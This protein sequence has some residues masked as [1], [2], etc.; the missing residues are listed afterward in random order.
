MTWPHDSAHVF[1]QAPWFIYM[2]LISTSPAFMMTA[3]L[4][5]FFNITPKVLRSPASLLVYSSLSPF[6]FFFY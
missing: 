4:L 1:V 5:E 6:E 2:V 3:N